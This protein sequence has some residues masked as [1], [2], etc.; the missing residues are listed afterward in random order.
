LNYPGW[1]SGLQL[2]FFL[3]GMGNS[4]KGIKKYFSWCGWAI[5]TFS[6]GFVIPNDIKS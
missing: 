3:M 2:I 6:K 1:Q 5:G 4:E